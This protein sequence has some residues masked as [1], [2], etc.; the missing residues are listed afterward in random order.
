MW[1]KTK[2]HEYELDSK[3]NDYEGREV[4]RLAMPDGGRWTNKGYWDLRHVDGRWTATRTRKSRQYAVCLTPAPYGVCRDGLWLTRHDTWTDFPSDAAEFPLD[5]E[6][7]GRDTIE[8]A[9]SAAMR[10]GGVAKKKVA[11]TILPW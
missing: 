4:V 5:D 9:G 6:K 1:T 2:E 8:G 7:Y 10:V 3:Y 11:G